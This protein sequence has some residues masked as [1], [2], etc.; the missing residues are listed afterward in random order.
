M[1]TE[2]VTPEAN[3]IVHF[4]RVEYYAAVKRK[5]PL[6]SETA[7]GDL[8]STMLSERSSQRKTSVS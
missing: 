1:L 5:E 4:S 6:P 7:W 2:T 8:G 3:T